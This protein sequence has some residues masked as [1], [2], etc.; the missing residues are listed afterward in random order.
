MGKFSISRLEQLDQVI[1]LCM[2]YDIHVNLRCVSLGDWASN[3]R[4]YNELSNSSTG[5]KLAAWWQAIA[6]R[7]ADIPNQYLSFM[8]YTSPAGGVNPTA[9]VLLPSVDAIREVSPDRCIIADVFGWSMKKA[10]AVAFAEAGVA[11][12]SRIGTDENLK[13]FYHREFFSDRWLTGINAAGET[14]IRNFQWPCN[15]VD[16]QSLLVS[17]KKD[18]VYE[19]M[20]VAEEYGVGFMVSDFG[21][22]AD[23]YEVY[24]GVFN[25]PTYRYPDEGYRAMIEDI[26]S[27]ITEKGYGWYFAN[28]FGYFGISDSAPVYDNV[29]YEQ[30]GDYPYYID[31]TMRSWFQEINGLK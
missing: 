9:G 1:A 29:T 28:W 8:L 6:R 15:G 13:L 5:P 4:P 14:F 31:T 17:T 25:Y 16:A 2:K 10:D 21:V 24:R 23:P 12:S 19:T 7:Y 11:L 20:G 27:A 18:R 26:T 22:V 30:V 3:N